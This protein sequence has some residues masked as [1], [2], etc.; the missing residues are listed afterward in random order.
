MRGMLIMNVP[1]G[2][3]SIEKSEGYLEKIRANLPETLKETYDVL[4]V[5]NPNG[6]TCSTEIVLYPHVGDKNE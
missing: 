3:M 1:I 5:A 6:V 4:L 2:N